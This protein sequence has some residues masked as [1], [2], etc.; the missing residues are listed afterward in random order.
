MITVEGRAAPPP[1]D[2]KVSWL[3]A[4]PA[5]ALYSFSGSGMPFPSRRMAMEDTPNHGCVDV[6]ADG[7]FSISL[8]PPNAYH[9]PELHGYAHPMPPQVHLR[10]TAGGREYNDTIHLR[11]HQT[12]ARV[13]PASSTEPRLDNDSRLWAFRSLLPACK[14][15][16]HAAS[17]DYGA[18]QEERLRSRSFDAPHD[19][20]V[21]AWAP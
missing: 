7:R 8:L 11:P 14:P 4:A 1:D 15:E 19:Q 16:S 6:G 12:P 21:P 20:H 10:W 3:A 5:A 9:E 13:A 2:G 17:G 18:T